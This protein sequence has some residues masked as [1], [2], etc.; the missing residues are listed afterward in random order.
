M[1][2]TGGLHLAC[3][4]NAGLRLCGNCISMRYGLTWLVCPV[5]RPSCWRSPTRLEEL[6][7]WRTQG[8]RGAAARSVVPVALGRSVR[9]MHKLSKDCHK[10]ARS[11]TGTMSTSEAVEGRAWATGFPNTSPRQSARKR[12]TTVRLP[13]VFASWR[14][15]SHWRACAGI[16]NGWQ[17]STTKWPIAYASRGYNQLSTAKSRHCL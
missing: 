3:C 16:Y 5:R 10:C 4:P 1:S 7:W 9:L 8:L 14:I 6:V 2:H 17:R 15:L 11:G 12:S 13:R